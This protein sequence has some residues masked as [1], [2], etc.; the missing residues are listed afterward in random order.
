MKTLIK[1]FVECDWCQNFT[2]RIYRSIACTVY[3]CDACKHFE[4][5]CDVER[6]N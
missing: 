5:D 1:A 2:L 6:E 3:E 4:V